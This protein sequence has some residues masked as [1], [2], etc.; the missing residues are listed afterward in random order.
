MSGLDPS[1]E[2]TVTLSGELDLAGSGAAAR[3][4]EESQALGARPVIVDLTRLSFIDSVGIGLLV[5]WHSVL[6]AA[7]VGLRLHG[8][9]GQV[10][11]VLQVTGLLEHFGVRPV[12]PTSGE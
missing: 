2:V 6:V 9:H 7:G 11:R 10:E 1:G 4:L 5:R 3:A 8:V 12:G